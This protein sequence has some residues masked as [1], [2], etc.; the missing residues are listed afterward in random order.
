MSPTSGRPKRRRRAATPKEMVFTASPAI[1]YDD[2]GFPIVDPDGRLAPFPG[3]SRRD[4][5]R[6]WADED[7]VAEDPQAAARAMHEIR[8]LRDEELLAAELSQK[9][10]VSLPTAVRKLYRQNPNNPRIRALYD[11]LVR[12]LYDR[13]DDA[14]R[15]A[16]P[17]A[18]DTMLNVM[19]DGEKDADRLKAAVYVFERMRGKTPDVLDVRQDKPF[20]VILERLI[21]GPRMAAER[22][23]AVE[24]DTEPLDAEIVSEA[25]SEPGTGLATLAEGIATGLARTRRQRKTAEE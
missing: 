21:A 11:D 24:E 15:S 23:N 10:L 20:Q 25:I 1:E 13:T 18:V 14:L 16:L 22:L 9:S 19:A 3:E 6:R 12:E 7:E 5:C 17:E 4:A 8:S 2:E